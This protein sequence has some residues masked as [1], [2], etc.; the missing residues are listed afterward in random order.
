MPRTHRETPVRDAT[1][2]GSG[3]EPLTKVVA[4]GLRRD[5]LEGVLPAGKRITQDSIAKKYGTSRIPVRE[6]LRELEAEGLVTI[7]PDVGARVATLD[8]AE[9]IEAYLMREALEPIA[10]HSSVE[11]AT[12]DQLRAMREALEHSDKTDDIAT[13]L[14]WDRRFHLRAL[15]SSSLPRVYRALE[16]LWDTTYRHGQTLALVKERREVGSLEHWLLLDAFERGDSEGA[17][18]LQQM[19]IRRSRLIVSALVTSP[20]QS[21]DNSA[22][23]PLRPRPGR[24]AISARGRALDDRAAAE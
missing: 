1:V 22:H 19:H 10:V 5:I 13:Y 16:R 17:A 2:Q 4:R 21:D 14:L 15:Q 24:S 7:V 11:H 12:G 6:A 3:D 8:P 23:N 20:D 9:L 18:E